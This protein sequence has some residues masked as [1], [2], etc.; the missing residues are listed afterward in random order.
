[1]AGGLALGQD[2][3]QAAGDLSRQALAHNGLGA[4]LLAGGHPAEARA[5]YD[6]ALG[7]SVE[8]GEKYE[9]AHAHDGLASSYQATGPAAQARRHWQ[10]ALAR[11]TE[12]GAPE[13]GDI[14]A[15]LGS[16]VSPR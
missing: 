3:D 12:V 10:E 13:A 14:R 5:E 4:V 15:K 9:Q 8:A 11:Y 7:A 2:Q 6:A 1:M 16:P